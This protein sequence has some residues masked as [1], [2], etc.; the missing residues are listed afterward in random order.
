MDDNLDEEEQV[1]DEN[2]RDPKVNDLKTRYTEDYLN[3]ELGRHSI[4]EVIELLREK[5]KP[6]LSCKKL[7]AILN[8]FAQLWFLYLIIF[9]ST[10]ISFT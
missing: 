9:F 3:L 5:W 8:L 7:V 10:F 2:T 1:L 6:F 4:L